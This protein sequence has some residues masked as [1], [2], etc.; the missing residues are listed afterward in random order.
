MNDETLDT[1]LKKHFSRKSDAGFSFDFDK[2][3]TAENK[4]KR[5]KWMIPTLTASCAVV[6]CVAITLT[7]LLWPDHINH[8]FVAEVSSVGDA[9]DNGQSTAQSDVEASE[10]STSSVQPGP[11]SNGPKTNTPSAQTKS[12][13]AFTV[14]HTIPRWYSPGSVTVRTLQ[15]G[16]SENQGSGSS[17][18]FIYFSNLYGRPGHSGCNAPRFDVTTGA[19]SCA[20]HE[21]YEAVKGKLTQFTSPQNVYVF[22][23]Y[24]TDTTAIFTYTDE[25]GQTND[26]YLYSF[27]SKTF[28]KSPYRLSGDCVSFS[29]DGTKLLIFAD[30]H[31]NSFIGGYHD[32]VLLD[33]K[34]GSSAQL[35]VDLSGNRIF[36]PYPIG[37]AGFSPNGR[38][39]FCLAKWGAGIPTGFRLQNSYAIYDTKT[40]KTVIL[41][42]FGAFSGNNEYYLRLDKNSLYRHHLETGKTENVGTISVPEGCEVFSAGYDGRMAA[43]WSY[44]SYGWDYRIVKDGTEI[45]QMTNVRA[46]VTDSQRKYL[47]WYERTND[48]ISVMSMETGETFEVPLPEDGYL[49][50]L[51][52]ASNPVMCLYVSKDGKNLALEYY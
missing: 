43:L 49:E 52:K 22:Y 10:M 2:L 20:N 19:V 15:S 12:E 11:A 25:D 29:S 37:N 42:G 46:A 3:E 7:V 16:P 9:S 44:N 41:D 39:A 14:T 17:A 48:H 8:G 13:S 23:G 38:Y 6:L 33:T 24:S 1:R 51:A 36:Y 30:G 26:Y 40:K 28:I 18:R 4:R 27:E 21:I 5:P 35:D 47:Y 45:K 32:L 31:E 50:M 34:T